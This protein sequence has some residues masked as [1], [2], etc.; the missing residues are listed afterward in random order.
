MDQAKPLMCE[1]CPMSRL[2]PATGTTME[3]IYSINGSK[4]FCY[5]S[6]LKQK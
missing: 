3:A 4:S 2:P 5:F 1:H 6:L